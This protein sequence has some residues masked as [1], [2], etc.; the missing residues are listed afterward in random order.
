MNYNQ[1]STAASSFLAFAFFAGYAFC[2]GYFYDLIASNE[3]VFEEKTEGSDEETKAILLYIVTAIL[4]GTTVLYGLFKC[5]NSQ[6]MLILRVVGNFCAMVIFLGF[7]C[8]V[9]NKDVSLQDDAKDTL[10]SQS[11]ST[12]AFALAWVII[13]TFELNENSFCQY[14]CTRMVAKAQ[15]FLFWVLLAVSCCVEGEELLENA[16]NAEDTEAK[17]S[18]YL[19]IGTAAAAALAACCLVLFS[20][21]EAME[22]IRLH[23]LTGS[24]TAILFISSI[25][26]QY[27]HLHKLINDE[28]D[29][30]EN[31]FLIEWLEFMLKLNNWHFAGALC[32]AL[33]ILCTVGFDQ[34]FFAEPTM[35][36]SQPQTSQRP[37]VTIQIAQ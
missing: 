10:S 35:K 22:F 9:L 25:G 32:G 15:L 7:K 20:L 8:E 26:H 4:C 31:E 13:S 29:E 37:G 11:E 33:S 16:K 18:A 28:I 1:S 14:Q 5:V 23:V 30:T 3:L 24:L 27:Y 12:V 36:S 34:F 6:C 2:T 19:L 17:T 21:C